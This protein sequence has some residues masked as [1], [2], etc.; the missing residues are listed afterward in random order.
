MKTISIPG[1]TIE[2]LILAVSGLEYGEVQYITTTGD[3]VKLREARLVTWNNP[4]LP[5]ITESSGNPDDLELFTTSISSALAKRLLSSI[6]EI[7]LSVRA[8]NLLNKTSIKWVWQLVVGCTSLRTI[9]SF[10]QKSIEEIRMKLID[11]S[12]PEDQQISSE[13]ALELR[14][15][16]INHPEFGTAGVMKPQE[17]LAALAKISNNI[18][19]SKQATLFILTT[20]PEIEL[21]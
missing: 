16:F 15:R 13:F 9:P 3:I 17:I 18:D 14:K 12:Y 11:D 1:K 2:N 8:A 19:L 4:V 21:R 7:E 5:E 6:N 20:V 10:G